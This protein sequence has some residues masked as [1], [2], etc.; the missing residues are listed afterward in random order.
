MSQQQP[1]VTESSTGMQNLAIVGMLLVGFALAYGFRHVEGTGFSDSRAGFWLGVLLL[2][3]GL[4]AALFGG[5]QI[6]TVD[7]R[8]RIIV[9]AGRGRFRNSSR[10]IRFDAIEG[11]SVGSFGQRSDGSVSYHV[12]LC[13]R[14]GEVVALFFA[15]FEGQYDQAVAAQRCQ[16]LLDMVQPAA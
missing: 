3:I 13:L 12:D 5:K 10:V 4:G 9:L 15:F 2:A 14:N 8:R 7:P 6:V 16:R 11:A 1:W